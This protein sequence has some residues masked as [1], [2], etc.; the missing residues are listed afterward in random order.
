MGS[1]S[2]QQPAMT[3][4]PAGADAVE[5]QR[6]RSRLEQSEDNARQ[7]ADLLPVAL[8]QVDAEGRYIHVNR[9]FAAW[10]D[11]PISSFIG[12]RVREV[13]GA[14][15][16]AV[17]GPH[18]E[19]ALAGLDDH[20]EGEV[21]YQHGGSR[22]ITADYVPSRD[23]DGTVRGFLAVLHDLTALKREQN[24][25]RQSE[26]NLRT[27]AETIPQLVFKTDAEGA[28]SYLSPAWERY[29]GVS[30]EGQPGE[31]WSPTVHPD[32]VDASTAAWLR[33]LATGEV[34]ET[35][36]RLRRADGMYRWHMVRAAPVHDDHGKIL[37]LIHI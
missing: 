9:A 14:D 23:Q 25:L 28:I 2:N 6:L 19:A 35:E 24:A 4:A 32:D 1:S 31:S 5:I 10:F 20:F 12:H 15:G 8:V 16:Y 36:Y 30:R 29:T 27:L 17:L 37:S 7:L 34:Y 33:A 11:M 22:Y 26:A 3:A 21:P 13:I 18:V